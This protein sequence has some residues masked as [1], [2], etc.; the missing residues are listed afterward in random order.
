MSGNAVVH[1]IGTGT[2]G[3]PLIGLLCEFREQLGI[4]EVTFHK[5]TP[6]LT[7][8]SKVISLMSKG[9]RLCVDDS[10]AKGFQNLGMEPSFEAVEAINRAAV[11][12]D[13]TPSGVGISNKT[14]YYEKFTKNTLGFIAQGSEFGF[15][16]PYARG[17]NDSALIRG[18]DKFIQVVSC[19]THNLS[20]LIQALALQDGGPDNLV[21]G[22]FVC[23]RRANDISQDGS[24]VPSPMV[25]RHKDER[26]GTHHA[27]DAWSLY[28]TMG[29]DL[30]LFST[31]IKLNTQYMHTI[32]FDIKVKS[33]TNAQR[34]IEHIMLNDRMALT[35][36][37]S[38]NA[39]FSFGRDQGHYGRILNV[40]VVCQPTLAVRN[41]TEIVGYC[42]T[43][44]DGNSLLSSLSA[45]TW[46]LYPNDYEDRVQCLKAWFYDEV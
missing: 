24:F 21:E 9:A 16:K 6:L 13:C 42:F 17:I 29:Y 43:P 19:N 35:Y 32:F 38:A 18:E 46:L 23:M 34:L 37:S 4:D 30:N 41:G 33:E 15:G 8:R 39:V 14:K 22:R 27:R 11:V 5:R 10:A 3:E 1:V 12:I 7:D 2:I 31:A 25:G 45:A 44:Q 26:F 28:N 36:K 20:I 40:T